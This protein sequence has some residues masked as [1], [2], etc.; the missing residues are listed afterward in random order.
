MTIRSK[1]PK[2]SI[3][4][5][6][7]AI[8]SPINHINCNAYDLTHAIR[9]V[10][11]CPSDFA[12]A[13]LSS[14]VWIAPYDMDLGVQVGFEGAAFVQELVLQGWEYWRHDVGE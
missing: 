5:K 3:T 11:Y 10:S 8:G 12:D 7:L 9:Q 4:T 14:T 13:L 2:G 6:N 1:G